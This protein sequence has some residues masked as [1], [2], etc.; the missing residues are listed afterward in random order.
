MAA[1]GIPASDTQTYTPPKPSVPQEP[2]ATLKPRENQERE[3]HE[4]GSQERG[5]QERG[6]LGRLIGSRDFGTLLIAAV[7]P[8]SIV[9]V[10]LLYFALPVQLSGQGVA[11]ADI[12]RVLML[13]GLTTIFLGPTVARIVDRSSNKKIFIPIAGLAGG[14]GLLLM[15]VDSSIAGLL[16]AVTALAVAGAMTQAA[17]ASYALGLDIVKNHGLNFS[18][19]LQRAADKF[20]QMLGPLVVGA[21]MSTLGGTVGLAVLG[22]SYACFTLLFFLLAPTTQTART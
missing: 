6:S 15:L 3:N 14:G 22:V 8:F 4:R 9:Q 12:G 16:F 18:F 19:S 7:I 17:Q 10:G 21:L 11:A 1:A 20:G 13:Y 5:S 2:S